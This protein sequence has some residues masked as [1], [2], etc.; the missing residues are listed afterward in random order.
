MLRSMLALPLLCVTSISTLASPTTPSN[1]I[2]VLKISSNLGCESLE[3]ELRPDSGEG[4][5]NLK[6]DKGAYAAVE[7]KPGNYQFGKVTCSIDGSYQVL[8]VLERQL[9][10]LNLIEEKIYFGGELVF[11]QSSALAL[12]DAP[13]VLDN[14]PRQI[15]RVRG[16]PNNSCRDGNGVN[17]GP[18]KVKKVDVFAPTINEQDISIVRSSFQVAESKV[19]YLPLR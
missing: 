19:A 5:Y 9:H 15:S 6:Y 2:Y 7:L 12:N 16:A 10:P 14:C 13:D 3:I 11:A 1:S 4:T 8:D 18:K 17:T